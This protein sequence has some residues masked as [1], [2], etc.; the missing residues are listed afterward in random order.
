MSHPML[1]AKLAAIRP[2]AEAICARLETEISKLGFPPRESR[3][4]PLPDL[5]HYHSETD[6]YSGEETL[7]GTWTNA[8]GYRIGGLK[9][10]GNGSFYAEFDVA[11]PHPTDRRWFVESVTAWGQGTE[12]KA[13]PQLIPA[14]E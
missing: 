10:H 6:P 4:R 14:L 1:D 12:I 11:E 3:P 7:V 8:R 9:F 13:E 5:A 2:L